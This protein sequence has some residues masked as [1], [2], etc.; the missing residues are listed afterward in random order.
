MA[1]VHIARFVD[2]DYMFNISAG[3]GRGR[4]NQ[5]LDVMLI[6]YLM[7]MAM[8]ESV[9]GA[10]TSDAPIRPPDHPDALKTDGICGKDTQKFIDHYQTFR[11]ANASF[12]GGNKLPIQ[13]AVKADGAI[14]P[15][16]YPIVLNFGLAGGSAL[17]PSYTLVTLCY[18]AAKNSEIS[19]GSF[20]TMPPELQR[21]LLAH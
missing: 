2:M 11:N 5:R 14:D 15:W 20:R 3:V 16:R 9:E 1:S 7:N 10:V 6:Q 19:Q 8:N 13:F 12:S 18:D 21:V 4:P 17:G